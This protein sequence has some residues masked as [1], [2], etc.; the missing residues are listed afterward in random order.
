MIEPPG[1][2]GGLSMEG[3]RYTLQVEVKRGLVD[4]YNPSKTYNATFAAY[5]IHSWGISSEFSGSYVD[6]EDHEV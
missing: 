6:M 1:S 3:K 4:C 5:L 2:G